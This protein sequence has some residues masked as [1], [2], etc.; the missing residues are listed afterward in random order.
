MCARINEEPKPEP[1]DAQI[2]QMTFTVYGASGTAAI[3]IDE[4]IAMTSKVVVLEAL[5]ETIAN[6]T[7]SRIPYFR[8]IMTNWLPH[9]PKT[10]EDVDRIRAAFNIPSGKDGP[11]TIDDVLAQ[12]K[13]GKEAHHAG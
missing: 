12:L 5:T 11:R 13:A 7:K 2:G 10:R 8:K 6:A 9:H 1:T 4:Y 3:E